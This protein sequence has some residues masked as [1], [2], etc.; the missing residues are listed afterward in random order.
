MPRGFCLFMFVLKVLSV[1]RGLDQCFHMIEI[2]LQCTTTSGRESILRLGHPAFER[3]RARDVVCFLELPRVD[4]QV[5]ISRIH[6]LLEI[7]ERQRV[8]H[9]ERAH[10]AKAK[11]L[12]DQSIELLRSFRGGLLQRTSLH[13]LLRARVVARGTMLSHRS[14]ARSGFQIQCEARR[15]LRRVSRNAR[16]PAQTA[17]RFQRR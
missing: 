17:Q 16:S 10:Y 5:S 6:Q 13:M 1:S 9:R 15:T 14:S 7:A 2:T 11:T 4:A 12:V 8:I 3:L